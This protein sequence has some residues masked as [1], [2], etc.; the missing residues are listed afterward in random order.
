[1]KFRLAIAFALTAC[2]LTPAAGRAA[3]GSYTQ[4]LCFNPDTGQGVG[5]PG[6]VVRLG[7]PPFPD[8]HAQCSGTV[9]ANSGM[10]LSSGEPAATSF[11]TAGEIEYRAPTSVSLV[12]GTIFRIFRASGAGHTVTMSQHA[13][14]SLDYFATPRSDLFQ[15]WPSGLSNVGS[16]SDPW[17]PTN[18]LE[19]AI[20]T[21]GVWRYTGACDVPEGCHTVPG[22]VLLRIYGGKLQLRDSSNPVLTGPPSGSLVDQTILSGAADVSLAASDT[23]TGIYRMRIIVDDVIRAESNFDVNG[24]KCVD[25][26]PSNTDPYEFASA[27]PCKGVA[28]SDATLDTRALSDGDHRLKVQIEDAGGNSTTVVNRGIRVRNSQPG[29]SPEIPATAHMPSGASR[30][31]GDGGPWSLSFRLSRRKLKNGQL[32]KYS[33]RLTGGQRA[34]R[35]VDVQVRKTRKRW[36]VVCSVQTDASG[37]Y[38]CRH[39]FKRT[40][41][42]TRYVF[43][44]RMRGQT[45]ASAQTIVTAPRAAVVRP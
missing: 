36:Q 29:G 4:I 44:A 24:G 19:L 2:L 17:S 31:L 39:R 1:M 42:K 10:T 34:R 7:G 22:S 3:D 12:S 35:F 37:A 43:R 6:E 40:H 23:G 16:S 41:R 18:R 20:S 14:P 45:G 25:V 38:S 8:Y 30:V 32:L 5:S 33:G 9:T 21:G 13:G 27:V 28:S 11:R 15:W 26:N